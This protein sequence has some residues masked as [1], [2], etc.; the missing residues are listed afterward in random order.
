MTDPTIFLVDDDA[1]VRAA[2]KFS[3]ELDGFHV[4]TYASAEAVGQREFP[5]GGCLVLDYR[6]PGANGLELLASLRRQGV[7]LPA[8]LMTTNPGAILRRQARDA[9]VALVEKPLLCDALACKVREA[10]A[11]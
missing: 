7:S 2:L 1:A 11:A 9:G 3:L 8:I 5:S 10:L 6:L 4:E